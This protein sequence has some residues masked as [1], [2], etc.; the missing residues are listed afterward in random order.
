MILKVMENRLTEVI[1]NIQKEDLFNVKVRISVTVSN[2]D[3][4]IHY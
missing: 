3:S 2:E 4:D 1:R